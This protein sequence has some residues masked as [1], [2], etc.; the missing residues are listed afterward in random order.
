MTSLDEFHFFHVVILVGKL[1]GWPLRFGL[2]LKTD[3]A[4][5]QKKPS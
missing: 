1:G 2:C 4:Q 3:A 5:K